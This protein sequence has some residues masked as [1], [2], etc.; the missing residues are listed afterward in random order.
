MLADRF[1]EEE[2]GISA[3][4]FKRA[5]YREYLRFCEDTDREPLS[6]EDWEYFN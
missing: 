1:E 6:F 5:E 2:I 4:V 3:S